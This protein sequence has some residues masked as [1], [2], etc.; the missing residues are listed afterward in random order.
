MKRMIQVTV[1]F[2]TVSKTV[3]V[4]QQTSISLNDL[5]EDFKC[6]FTPNS[7]RLRE[8]KKIIYMYLNIGDA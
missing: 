5:D 7:V 3:G 1:F 6:L 4:K 8:T 2:S